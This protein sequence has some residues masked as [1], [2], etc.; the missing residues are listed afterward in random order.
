VIVADGLDLRNTDPESNQLSW[1]PQHYTNVT[2]NI[3]K[4]IAKYD[5]DIGQ[6][7]CPTHLRR[8][9]EDENNFKKTAIFEILQICSLELADGVKIFQS[10]WGF[11]G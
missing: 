2:I 3:N 6:S 1:E 8:N 7:I 4:Y 10:L 9:I 11:D 5:Y